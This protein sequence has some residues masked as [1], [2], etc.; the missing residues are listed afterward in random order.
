MMNYEEMKNWYIKVE[1]EVYKTQKRSF[2]NLGWI[3]NS[4]VCG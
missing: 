3:N 4:I 2:V 1:R